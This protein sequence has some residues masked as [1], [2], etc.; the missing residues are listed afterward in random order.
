MKKALNILTI[1]FALT[2]AISAQEFTASVDKTIVGQYERFQVYFTFKE[3]DFNKANN[4]TP[5]SFEGFRVLSG[6]NRSVS[7][8]I[9]NGQMSGSLT[10][11]FILQPQEL[12]DFTIGAAS[13]K[14]EGKTLSTEPFGV[15]IVQQG[16]APDN[17]GGSSITEEQLK[18]NVFIRAIPDKYNVVVGE[19]ILVRYKLYVRTQIAQPTINALP[20]F[21]GFWSQELDPP[22]NTNYDFEMYNG[23]RYRSAEIQ[24]VAL[25][26]TKAG[27]LKITPFELNIPVVVKSK[28][29]TSNDVFDQ[30]FNDSYFGR[31][32]TIDYLA[33]S[34]TITVKVKQLKRT[35]VPESFNGAVG[36]FS[37][38]AELSST[39]TKQNEPVSLRITVK[40]KGNI[41]L[42]KMPEVKLPAGF[43]KYDPETSQSINKKSSVVSGEK[44][45]EYL[46]V[47]R[48]PGKKV[49]P[50]IEFS[51]YSLEQYRY[52]TLQSPS[53]EL[54]VIPGEGSY[55][56]PVAGY[57]KENVKLLSEDI[58]FIQT[59]SFDFEKRS[60]GK[61]I[62]VWFWIVMAAPLLL[63]ITVL[64]AKRRQDK[65]SGNVELVK[66]RK[67]EKAAKRRLK[68]AKEALEQ[69][70]NA[71]FYDELSSALFGYLED[72]LS[73]QKSEFT[74]N[75]AVAQ[76]QAKGV[77]DELVGKVK[78]I[79]EKCE[80]ARFAPGGDS[81]AQ[82]LYDEAVTTII[83]LDNA[84]SSRKK[85]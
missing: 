80:F 7:T 2:T 61:M 72:K 43:E 59:S 70:D 35:D 66:F 41:N 71:K 1:I 67:A 36:E 49:I 60:D 64:T 24:R 84:I 16:K 12:G 47:P 28:K 39:E 17:R 18:E 82:D 34:N 85:K 50:P 78:M 45:V 62:P 22:A 8:Q 30:F 55:D 53:F 46:I 65:L 6:P 79:S 52:V 69:H 68:S 4:F 5:P 40:G 20:K 27:E 48:A 37:L 10:Y 73:I 25:F 38:N 75:K 77:S 15:E 74:L 42:I 76:L 14:Y 51:Y 26:P 29:S 57:N 81:A 33:K 56:T 13:L 9:I 3:G 19:Q 31:T 44:K 32:E 23:M 83:N 58:R 11:S 63:L 21:E 54:N